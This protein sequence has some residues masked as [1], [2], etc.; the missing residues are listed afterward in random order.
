M[1]YTDEMLSAYL[2]GELPSE[3]AAALD[4]ALASDDA[5]KARLARLHRAN[6]AV[7]EAYGA[8]DET[9]IP[10]AVLGLLKT[11]GGAK[12]HSGD[13]IAFPKF[14]LAKAASHWPA[15][16]A[17]S[18]ALLAGLMIGLYGPFDRSAS[19]DAPAMLVAGD[20]LPDNPIFAALNDGASGVAV[21]IHS[22][23]DR[24]LYLQPI[25]SFRSRDGGYCRE[26]LMSDSV[27]ATHSV[28][29]KSGEAWRINVAVRSPAIDLGKEAYRT[30][31]SSP[32]PL[33]DNYVG[34]II[35]GDAF[36]METEKSLMAKDWK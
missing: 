35:S 23:T 19:G 33:I 4:A 3:V 6:R 22:D 31:S 24:N 18:L 28:A 10:E 25:L 14:P 7:R 26:F 34:Q 16:M 36:D 20:I 5:L 30:A 17:A 21:N 12:P 2:D 9:P 15:A 29:C 27:A 13:V 1:T 8:I 11:N 32:D